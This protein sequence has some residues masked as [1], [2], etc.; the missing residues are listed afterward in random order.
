[1]SGRRRWP[2]RRR[3]NQYKARHEECSYSV[4]GNVLGLA[5]AFAWTIPPLLGRLAICEPKIYMI[6]AKPRC[7]FD[8][9]KRS[10]I[11]FFTTFHIPGRIF[12]SLVLNMK[13]EVSLSP[14]WRRSSDS[15]YL[16]MGVECQIWSCF[17]ALSSQ[18]PQRHE[19]STETREIDAVKSV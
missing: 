7:S 19:A 17:Q 1:M 11:P 16:L 4:G 2:S 5:A 15:K 13:T 10:Y 3:P 6:L 14:I 18:Y 9:C 8:L 12:W